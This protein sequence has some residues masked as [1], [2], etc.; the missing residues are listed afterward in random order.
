MPGI[1][2]PESKLKVIGFPVRSRFYGQA[3]ERNSFDVQREPDQL[4][5]VC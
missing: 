4:S 5:A 3:A 1:S 2:N